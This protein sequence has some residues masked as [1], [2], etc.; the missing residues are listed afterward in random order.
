MEESDLNVTY[1]LSN[2]SPF[3]ILND[4]TIKCIGAKEKTSNQNNNV[5]IT[6]NW[7]LKS[8]NNFK[9]LII[10]MPKSHNVNKKSLYEYEL[11]GLSI[12]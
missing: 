1:V 6:L 3:D 10:S 8:N 12:R 2:G 7:N 9:E 5:D 11:T 4:A